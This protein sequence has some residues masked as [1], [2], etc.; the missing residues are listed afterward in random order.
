MKSGQYRENNN[1]LT[2]QSGFKSFS[3]KNMSG[4]ACKIVKRIKIS[5]LGQ[6]LRG[7]GK[8]NRL[9]SILYFS[10]EMSRNLDRGY[11]VDTLPK[12]SSDRLSANLSDISF[13][14]CILLPSSDLSSPSSLLLL[15]LLR[16]FL[17][18]LFSP[19]SPSDLSQTL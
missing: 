14:L 17:L 10:C 12:R 11:F 8:I 16:M 4:P 18:L 9:F 2:L 1:F 13:I 5:L 15:L 3:D 6:K 7:F 19:L